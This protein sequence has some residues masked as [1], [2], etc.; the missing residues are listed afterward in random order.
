MV[1]RGIS[2]RKALSSVLALGATVATLGGL[3][4]GLSLIHI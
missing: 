3:V 1:R 2:R 4:H